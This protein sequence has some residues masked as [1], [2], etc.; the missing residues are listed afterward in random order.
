[1]CALLK[2]ALKEAYNQRS[3]PYKYTMQWSSFLFKPLSSC[4]ASRFETEC[5]QSC[6]K[7]FL[8][9]LV[10][11]QFL[12]SVIESNTSKTLTRGLR[13]LFIWEIWET[14]RCVFCE[15]LL[16]M[17]LTWYWSLDMFLRMVTVPFITEMV[18]NVNHLP[19]YFHF[20]STQISK[21]HFT[22][23][24]NFGHLF[25]FVSKKTFLFCFKD[26]LFSDFQSFENI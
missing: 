12:K 1:M 17:W 8:T 19:D 11:S 20:A 7:W 10:S 4:I 26:R 5:I 3:V 21:Y 16:G 9:K 23:L 6:L 13:I 14:L 22:Q 2:S 25:Y 15:R 18:K 24:I